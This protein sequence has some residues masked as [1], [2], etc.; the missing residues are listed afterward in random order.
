ML[1]LAPNMPSALN[2]D[3]NNSNGYST[4][5][6]QMHTASNGTSKSAIVNEFT[7]EKKWCL[8]QVRLTRPLKV[9][10]NDRLTITELDVD[11]SERRSLVEV[12]KAGFFEKSPLTWTP[13]RFEL[14][15]NT[16][17]LDDFTRK[18]HVILHLYSLCTNHLCLYLL[19]F[20]SL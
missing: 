1:G 11:S 12:L 16:N 9:Y 20:F 8:Q 5:A 15:E 17:L 10:A 14:V 2:G 19:F 18:F 4:S 3:N 7:N 13:I 6:Q